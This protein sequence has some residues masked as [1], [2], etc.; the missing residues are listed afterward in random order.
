MSLRTRHN[1]NECF[2]VVVDVAV[3]VATTAVVAAMAVCYLNSFV[4]FKIYKQM[5]MY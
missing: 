1:S 4:S 2:S 5:S 3:V